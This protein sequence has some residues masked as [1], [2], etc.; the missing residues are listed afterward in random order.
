[1][2][3]RKTRSAR[4]QQQVAA[5]LILAVAMAA[6]GTARADLAAAQFSQRLVASGGSGGDPV[7][8][9]GSEWSPEDFVCRPAEVAPTA[10][11]RSLV[12]TASGHAVGSVVVTNDG[13]GSGRPVLGVKTGQC[14][15]GTD[16]QSGSQELVGAKAEFVIT[17]AKGGAPRTV[18]ATLVEPQPAQFLRQGRG[19]LVFALPALEQPLA[20]PE[21]VD[22]GMVSPGDRVKL[23]LLAFGTMTSCDDGS[24]KRQPISAGLWGPSST[25]AVGYLTTPKTTDTWVDT[26]VAPFK[27]V[28]TIS[29]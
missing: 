4:P 19:R 3:K 24:L 26:K 10:A 21:P 2:Q 14:P 13:F 25:Q 15:A 16:L 5:G 1:M 18:S 23:R 29:Y 8:S 22:L 9:Q 20:T 17:P 6:A 27:A 12:I 7:C 11:Q 28:A